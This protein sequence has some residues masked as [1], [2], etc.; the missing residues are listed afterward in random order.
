MQFD[1]DLN[2][3]NKCTVKP[4][5]KRSIIIHETKSNKTEIIACLIR[6]IDPVLQN[7]SSPCFMPPSF[8]KPQ[9]CSQKCKNY[10]DASLNLE[11]E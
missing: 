5:L 2:N 7:S 9:I 8:T 11:M 10:L 3:G 4:Y 1:P 6:S